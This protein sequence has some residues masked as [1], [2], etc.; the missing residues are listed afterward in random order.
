M[1]RVWW[2]LGC[3]Q[4]GLLPYWSDWSGMAPCLET[5][6]MRGRRE[7]ISIVM[8]GN[9]KSLNVYSLILCIV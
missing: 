6:G 2:G 7:K 1:G 3:P 5:W 8:H 4:T 9:Y